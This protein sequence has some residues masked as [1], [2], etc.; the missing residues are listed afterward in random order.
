M[1][2]LLTDLYHENKIDLP[3]LISKMTCKPSE[4]FGLNRGNLSV[5]NVADVT[6]IDPNLEW[7]VDEKKFYTRGSHSPFIGRKLKGRAI[8]TI[9]EG[10]IIET[11]QTKI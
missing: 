3:A 8:G 9:V 4:I 2:I 10:R 6:I 7:I 11:N 1:G 5:G